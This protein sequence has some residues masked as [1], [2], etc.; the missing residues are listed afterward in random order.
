VYLSEKM[1]IPR[2]VNPKMINVVFSN[3]LPDETVI[4]L[5]VKITGKIIT[6][7]GEK[8]IKMRQQKPPNKRN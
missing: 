8:K 7:N 5:P 1:N 4:C 6:N 3:F 2:T